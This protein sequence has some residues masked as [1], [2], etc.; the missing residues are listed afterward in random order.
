MNEANGD[1]ED[2]NNDYERVENVDEDGQG[3]NEK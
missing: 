1:G 2:D 3:P